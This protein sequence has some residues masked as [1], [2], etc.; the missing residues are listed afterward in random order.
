[1]AQNFFSPK[2]LNWLQVQAFFGEG[3]AAGACS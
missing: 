2:W 3:K 1:M